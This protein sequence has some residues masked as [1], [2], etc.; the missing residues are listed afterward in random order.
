LVPKNGVEYAIRGF[1]NAGLADVGLVIAGDGTERGFLESLATDLGVDRRVHFLGTVDK[2]EMYSLLKTAL[3]VIVPSVP[4]K[5]VVEA[6]SFSVLE[7]MA[8]GVPVI[9]SAIGGIAEIME[10]NSRGFLVPPGDVAAIGSAI[11]TVT[12]LDESS[13][14]ILI[15]NARNR[16]RAGFGVERWFDN[17]IAV[18]TEAI[19]SLTDADSTFQCAAGLKGV[20]NVESVV[21]RRS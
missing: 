21:E 17:I 19:D 18:Y 9:G 2:D 10:D 13:R 6:T 20:G 4:S 16:V 5:G 14:T 11:R 15:R 3:A 7:A 8:V 12:G 1:A